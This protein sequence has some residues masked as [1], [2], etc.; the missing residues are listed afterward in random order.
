MIFIVLGMHKSG[1]TLV[2]QI[3]H[4]SGIDM[5]DFDEGI[6]YD[7]GNKYER[8][9]V[10]KM[11]QEI[12]GAVDDTVI[13]LHSTRRV[14]N[15]QD[16]LERMR[17]IVAD[18][19]ARFPD[20]GFKEPRSVLVYDMWREVLPEHR[21]V[22]IY[23]DPVQ[24]WSRFRRQGK[25]FYRNFRLAHKYLAMWQDHNL[26]LVRFLE[27]T[28]CEYLLLNY[29]DLMGDE[30]AFSLLQDFV[31]RPLNDRRKPGLYRNRAK[32]SFFLGLADGWMKMNTGVSVAGTM[33]RLDELSTPLGD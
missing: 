5:G 7:K 23:R 16:Q 6:S 30:R 11:D 4:H 18:C 21:I 14:G 28:S 12:L 19:E 32:R 10:L 3:L 27:E 8:Q 13:D 17:A 22:A 2:S 15:R 29:R 26:N 1:T 20:W 25:R 9:S 31:G 33:A 24:V